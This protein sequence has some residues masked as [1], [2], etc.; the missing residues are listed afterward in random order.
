VSTVSDTQKRDVALPHDERFKKFIEY[1]ALSGNTSEAA[2][3]A[4]VV[5]RTARGWIARSDVISAIHAYRERMI[6]THGASLALKTLLAMVESDATPANVRFQA[7]S[8]LLALAGHAE[9]HAAADAAKA[10]AGEALQD[11][12]ADQLERMIAGAAATLH[13]LRRQVSVVDVAPD[14]EPHPAPPA[15]LL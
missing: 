7:A 3:L 5:E 9:A 12:S 13:Q 6:K 2:R 14:P 15:S 8:K 10:K 11:M 1:Q 4:G